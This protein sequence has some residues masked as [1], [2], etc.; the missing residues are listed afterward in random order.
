MSRVRLPLKSRPMDI[1]YFIFFLIH[2]PATIL[3]DLQVLYPAEFVPKA[4]A[5]LPKWY[6]QQYADP[7]IAGVF[8]LNG[9][10]ALWVWL[11]SFMV[12]E[13]VFQ[14][15]VF[16]IG[17]YALWTDSFVTYPLF[18]IYS[19]S[20]TTSTLPCISTLLRTPISSTPV[21][22]VLLD[23]SNLT[24]TPEQRINLLASYL[25]FF[26]IQLV[27]CVDMSLRV[28]GFVAMAER[29]MEQRAGKRA[30]KEKAQ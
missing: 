9:P 10:P 18:L 4:I 24:I 15:P 16:F 26:V 29:G 13:A 30:K 11:K 6:L 27:M 17:L 23:P 28:A 5:E 8:D 2:I 25:P 20:A 19:A 12:L 3:I 1:I 7:I 14:L 21:P 22:P